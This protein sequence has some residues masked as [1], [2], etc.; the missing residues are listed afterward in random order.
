MTILVLNRIPRFVTIYGVM[1]MLLLG[2]API[3]CIYGLRAAPKPE[4]AKRTRGVCVLGFLLSV[5]LAFC[6]AVTTLQPLAVV[7][8]PATL[9]F[10]CGMFRPSTLELKGVRIYLILCMAAGEVFWIWAAWDQFARGRA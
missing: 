2:A 5:F 4:T 10:V 7:I 6:L 3:A 9:I 8:L 1:W